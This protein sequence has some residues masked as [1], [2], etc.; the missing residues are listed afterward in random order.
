MLLL[1]QVPF[2]RKRNIRTFLKNSE[3]PEKKPRK[4]Y[5]LIKLSSS[6]P[7]PSPWEA[8]YLGLS[9]SATSCYGENISS[10]TWP[11]WRMRN[12]EFYGMRQR[13]LFTGD[14]RDIMKLL[15]NKFKGFLSALFVG[16]DISVSSVVRDVSK[17]F[18]KIREE[19]QNWWDWSDSERE[20][21]MW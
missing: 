8:S 3:I 12:V 5:Q 13:I 1:F 7:P 21:F 10:P 19:Q 6:I 9:I 18:R 17:D 4:S 20:S 11:T 14:L 16:R 2:K 15:K